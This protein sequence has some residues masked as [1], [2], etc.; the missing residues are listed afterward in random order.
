MKKLSVLLFVVLF[1]T[2]QGYAQKVEVLYFKANL[3]CC[4]A[5][6]CANLEGQIK[7]V[8]EKNFKTSVVAFKTIML[9]DTAQ[10]ELINRYNAKSQTVVL[11]QKKKKNPQTK[12]VSEMVKNFNRTKDEAVFEKDIVA[13][14]KELL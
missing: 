12:D 2:L 10:S 4:A 9:N 6:A 5:K 8:V 3:A 14:I 13:A 1:F 11:V 7:S